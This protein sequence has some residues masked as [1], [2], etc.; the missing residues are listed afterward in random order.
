MSDPIRIDGLAAVT[1]KVRDWARRFPEA[2]QQ[3]TH[4]AA[5]YINAF[6]K[7]NYLSGQRLHVRTDKL[8]GGFHVIPLETGAGSAIVTNTKYAP[9]HEYGFTGN[10][11]VREHPRKNPDHGALKK[12]A[13][14]ERGRIK[15]LG[16]R[17]KVMAIRNRKATAEAMR[18]PGQRTWKNSRG[19]RSQKLQERRARGI[20][21]GISPLS[22][23]LTASAG[24]SIVRAHER[25][26]RVRAKRYARDAMRNG[27]PRAI[28]I[29]LRRIAIG[30]S[31]AVR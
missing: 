20:Q 26:M 13:M 5:Q 19:L 23:N 4:D 8:R 24:V 29:L 11:S 9:V 18:D 14:R 16:A 31:N 25:Y 10:V 15:R 3:G 2:T 27:A 7:D 12:K 17:G 22:G 30:D 1:S 6:M 21:G 28:Q